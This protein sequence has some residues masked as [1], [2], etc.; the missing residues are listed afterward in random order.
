[1][2][3]EQKWKP[4]RNGK[5]TKQKWNRNQNETEKKSELKLKP[6]CNGNGTEMEQK[7][8]WN[9]NRNGTEMEGMQLYMNTCEYTQMHEN[10]HICMQTYTCNG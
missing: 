3:T 4:N 9:R 2:E 10:P 6:K 1:M 8:K 7:Q 5:E